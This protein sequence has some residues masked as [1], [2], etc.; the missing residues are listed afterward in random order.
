M[1]EH[2][3]D[4]YND[5]LKLLRMGVYLARTYPDGH[6][7]QMRT[8]QR[9]HKLFNELRIEKRVV[10]IVVIENVLTIE[11]ERFDS[12]KISIVKYLVDRFHQIGVNSITFNTEVSESDLNEF[13]SV[14][15]MQP[16]DIEDFGDVVAVM[17]M[18]DITGVK[19][20]IY[21]VGVVSS[22]EDMRELDWE[23]FL[24]S[25]ITAETPKTE[26]E[27][28]K[29]LGNFL[30]VLGVDGSDSTEI[31]SNKIVGGLE[32]LALM[33]VDRYGEE[34]WNEYSLVFSRILAVL[35][36]SVKKNIVRYRTEN[37]KLA[38]LFRKLVPTMDDEDIVDIVVTIA[39]KK[40]PRS[41]DDVV[42]ILSNVSSVKLPDILTTLR[43]RAPEFYTHKFVDRLMGQVKSRKGPEAATKFVIRNL[44]L[45]MKS[46]FPKLRS[47]K[48]EERIKAIEALI[49]FAGKLF[50]SKNYDLVRLMA[51]RLDTMAE[52]ESDLNAFAKAIDAM[53]I[54]YIKA[55][56]DEA[57]E[58]MDFI[59]KKYAKYLMR[60]DSIFL[61]R[62]R[63]VIK[64]IGETKDP[65]YIPELISS[66]WAAGTYAEAREALIALADHSA[67]LLI[68]TLRET[69]DYS[70]R[71][72]ILDILK[73]MTDRVIPEVIGLLKAEE[74]YA[75]R[76]GVFI[77]G[78]LKAESTVDD[79][80]ALLNEDIEQIQLEV[81][82]SLGKIGGTR[83]KEY[84]Q[85][86]LGSKYTD[87]TLEAMKNLDPE[88]FKE[89]I[90]D[91]LEWLKRQKRFPD[92]AEEQFR[93]RVIDVLAKCKYESVINALTAV[94]KERAWFK[95]NL[96]QATKTAAL[97]ALAQIGTPKAMQVLQK[98][99]NNRNQF[100]ALTAQDVLQRVTTIPEETTR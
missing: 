60:K 10:S 71:M 21:R 89:K 49:K 64:A 9:L 14:M 7:S 31:Q 24:E 59:A 44:E 57:S 68:Q 19:V 4:L 72:K 27:R 90:P 32:K 39:K 20:N 69:E 16:S 1:E 83:C 76:N 12:Q 58:V 75:R 82:T 25:L 56:E 43:Q 15:S 99:A 92:E 61:E 70:V 74:W 50:E 22:D 77:L 6:P 54:L 97:N 55:H 35:S 38:D 63:F 48:A 66:L 94:I 23:N 13:F 98:A 62:K 86:A 85:K 73:R 34:R 67:P 93:S 45:E 96:L 8:V 52:A 41:E 5:L 81:V 18:R 11:N 30:G 42:D 17:R 2:I 51:N 84:I 28:L 46:Q 29:E 47:A 37:K 65:T 95:G 36:P 91:V 79:I 53:K 87:V 3:L 80:G 88:D 26:E 40:S 100:I 33:V 78:E